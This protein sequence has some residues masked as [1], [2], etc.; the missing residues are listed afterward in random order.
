LDLVVEGLS[1]LVDRREQPVTVGE[2]EA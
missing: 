2:L 1:K